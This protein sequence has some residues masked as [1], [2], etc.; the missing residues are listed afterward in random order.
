MFDV[1]DRQPEFDVD[2]LVLMDNGRYATA[3]LDE[4]GT[5]ITGS[6]ICG[7]DADLTGEVVKWSMLNVS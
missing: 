3:F 4:S 2:V 7:A 5:W 6:G 1:K